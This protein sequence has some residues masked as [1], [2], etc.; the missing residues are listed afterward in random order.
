MLVSMKKWLSDTVMVAIGNVFWMVGGTLMYVLWVEGA[1]AWHFVL[2]IVLGISGFPFIGASNRSNYTK[3]VA[4][5]PE[6]EA[7]Q[8]VMQSVLSMV[9]S[10]AGFTTPTVIAAFV[11]R[12][13]EDVDAS[14]DKHELTPLALYIPVVSGIC[15]FGLWRAY[16]KEM[17]YRA[18]VK[19]Q[20]EA[21]AAVSRLSET[22]SLLENRAQRKSSVL[23]IDQAF[24]K[25]TEVSRRQSVE[26]MGV[27]SP[28]ESQNEKNQRDE[29]WRQK[30]ELRKLSTL[31]DDELDKLAAAGAG[32]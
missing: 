31:D 23:E 9:T 20:E 30:I 29:M 16:L 8:S 5:I 2:P 6:L 18:E 3:A 26:V 10:I 15:I 7:S 1:Q 19:K 4:N 11:I 21:K 12:S 13:P 25:R 22:T 17:Q 32:S 28:F 14:D 24:S 27:S